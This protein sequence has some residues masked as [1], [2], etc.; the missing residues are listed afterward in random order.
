MPGLEDS[1]KDLMCSW[2]QLRGLWAEPVILETQGPLDDIKNT[3]RRPVN[4]RRGGADG[5]GAGTWGGQT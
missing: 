5:M 1:W 2:E 4:W 3:G